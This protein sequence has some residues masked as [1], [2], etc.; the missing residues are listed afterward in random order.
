MARFRCRACGHEGT[1]EYD[2]QHA[3][4]ECGSRDVQIALS[5]KDIK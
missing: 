2:G 5:I 3:C 4:P 1:F